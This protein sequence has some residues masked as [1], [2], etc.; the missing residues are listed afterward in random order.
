M[1]I[2]HRTEKLHR[3]NQGSNFLALKAVLVIEIM[4]EPQSNLEEKVNP[5]IL[6]DEFSSRTDPSFFRSTKP[7]LLAWF[8][9]T[10]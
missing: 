1:Q 7:V 10:S 3:L 6:K 2:N 4:S 5:S 8:N 9:E